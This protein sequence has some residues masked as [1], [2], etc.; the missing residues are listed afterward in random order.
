MNGRQPLLLVQD[1]EKS[2]K[3]HGKVLDGISFQLHPNE[4]KVLIGSSGGGKS[5]LL[6]CINLLTPYDKGEIFLD[7]VLI[8]NKN[9]NICRQEIGFVFQH[10]NLFAHLTALDNVTLGPTTVKGVP[11]KQAREYA[12]ELL[13]KVGLKDKM[14]NYPAELSGGQKQRLGIARA[15]GMQPQLILFDEPTSALDPELIGEVLRIMKDLAK[16]GMTMLIV[17]HEMGFAQAVSNEI[18]FIEN[19]KIIEQGPPEQFSDPVQERTR[20]FLRKIEEQ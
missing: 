16:E 10:F 9:K 8:R 3:G 12:L 5:T 11:R 14:F 15:L 13:E 4:V 1:L 18:I 2:Y 7:G 20:Q 6:Q 19:G 17:T